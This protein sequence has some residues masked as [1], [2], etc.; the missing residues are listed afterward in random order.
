MGPLVQYAAEK[1][2]D[3]LELRIYPGANGTFTLYEDE[4]D[5]YNY[6]KG[7]Y[8]TITFSWNDKSRKLTVSA[9]KGAY[10]GM[11]DKRTFRVVVVGENR[12]TGVTVT[13]SIDK[14]VVYN[15]KVLEI[16]M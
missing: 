1:P 10:P 2:A 4:N 9:R 16:K 8:A 3:P 15:G 6:E 13:E 12:G 7:K 14:E 5:N 11:P